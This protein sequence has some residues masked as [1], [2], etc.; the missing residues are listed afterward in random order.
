MSGLVVVSIGG[1]RSADNLRLRLKT[2]VRRFGVRKY[3]G[4]AV[5]ERDDHPYWPV[6][7]CVAGSDVLGYRRAGRDVESVDL[8][9]RLPATACPTCALS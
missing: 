6:V 5:N 7:G 4:V 2:K 3:H 9:G 8:S 1:H